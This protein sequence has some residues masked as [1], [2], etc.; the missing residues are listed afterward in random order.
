MDLSF[1]GKAFRV[2]LAIITT[3]S[4]TLVSCTRQGGT[5]PPPPPSGGGPQFV[6]NSPQAGAL[7]SGPV[8][9]S[10]QPLNPSEVRSVEFKAGGTKLEVNPGLGETM[11]KVFLVPTEFPD[12]SL[13][14]TATVTGTNGRS[15]EQSVTVENVSNPPGSATVGPDGAVLGSVEENGSVST[16]TIPPGVGEG[17]SVSFETRTTAEVLATTGV[18]YEALGV[19]FLGAQEIAADRPLEGPLGISSG[20]FG[21]MVQPGQAVVNYMIIPDADSD[22]IGELVVVNSASVAPNGDVISDP[23]PQVQVATTVTTSLGGQSELQALQNGL[24]G[25]PGT[26]LEFEVSG[27]MDFSLSSNVAMFR[28]L[29]DDSELEVIG[30]V[31]PSAA[32]SAQTFAVVIPPLPPGPATLLLQNETTRSV[33]GPFDLEVEPAEP[34]SA[35]ATEI[36]DQFLTDTGLLVGTLT[37]FPVEEVAPYLESAASGVADLEAKLAELVAIRDSAPPEIATIID[38]FLDGAALLARSANTGAL[39]GRSELRPA[40]T[41]IGRQENDLVQEVA[42]GAFALST[43]AGSVAAVLLLSGVGAG[44]AAVLAK[45]ALGAASLG[46]TIQATI[47][48]LRANY[49]YCDELD[50]EPASPVACSLTP[51]PAPS[52]PAVLAPQQ[53]G[54]VAMSGMGSLFP[55]GGDA[56]GN[57]FGNTSPPAGLRTAQAG[58][59][60]P[61]PFLVRVFSFNAAQPFVGLSDSS[62]Y[63]Y[64]PGIPAG[65]PFTAVARDLVSGAVRSVEG[66]GPNLG[67]STFLLFNFLEGSGS[68]EAIPIALDSNTTGF[69]ADGEFIDLFRFSGTAG[70]LVNLAL[71]SSQLVG[72]VF[73]SVN[74][75]L[76]GPSSAG[77]EIAGCAFH[78]SSVSSHFCETDV[79]ELPET[80][81]Y[82]I[83]LAS[84]QTGSYTLGLAAIEPPEP[85]DL[86]GNETQL[87]GTITVL[88]DHQYFA[89]DGTAVDFQRLVLSHPDTSSLQASLDLLGVPISPVPFYQRPPL[90]ATRTELDLREASTPV[91]RL[92]DSGEYVLEVKSWRAGNFDPPELRLGSYDIVIRRQDP[93]VITRDSETVAA[94]APH[95]FS[96]FSFEG[97]AG[98]LVNLALLVDPPF[99]FTAQL[100]EP[101]GLLS[102]ITQV[103]F[104]V[105]TIGNFV[106]SG[107]FALQETGTHHIV[108]AGRD[109]AGG[110]FTLGL[111]IIEAPAPLTLTPPSTTVSG[112]IDVLGDHRFYSFDGAQDDMLAFTL[113][114]PAGSQLSTSL[115][116]R[117]PPPAFNPTQ[118]FY[119][120][121]ELD[122]IQTEPTT[123]TAATGPLTLPATGAYILEVADVFLDSEDLF[124]NLPLDQRK[125]AFE[126]I[127]AVP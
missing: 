47:W 14:L 25:P 64:L 4:I 5:T 117:T 121:T 28:S 90:G 62:G 97:S 19:T 18:D 34:L 6:I 59:D 81:E 110:S 73:N 38:G 49:P 105:N 17:A 43:L 91:V 36:L 80:G 108:V 31:T 82:L 71:Y 127:I 56:C 54:S 22:G 96:L 13:E 7:V 9:F 72:N 51:T 40:Q 109:D 16:L 84:T 44:A 118:P 92:P 66:V 116:V 115:I 126:L 63:F 52:P 1:S 29:V 111:P 8:F 45:V 89:F 26:T 33:A 93:G 112:S 100:V 12:G 123:R 2:L 113:G 58:S 27:F 86:T 88:G 79:F 99:L 76:Y 32:G 15:R 3:V 120:R 77:T 20:G 125:G 95:D 10:V 69:L 61:N 37:E 23:V 30:I 106:E 101:S 35:P 83:E 75:S 70:Q 102:V 78:R 68:A 103:P 114:H 74:L 119:E 39:R 107:V 85:F 46:F 41:C 122:S 42:N 24:G 98:D 60:V 55:P 57:G 94:V 11:F 124:K 53:G 67:D 65:R 48:I 21:P 104:S 50:P 87:A